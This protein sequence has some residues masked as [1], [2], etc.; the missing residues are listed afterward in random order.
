MLLTTI[1]VLAVSLSALVT[2]PTVDQIY[3]VKRIYDAPLSGENEVPPVQSSATGLAEFTPP[4]NDTIK[5]RINIT[6][7]SGATGAH[8][9][10]GQ[11]GENG[12]VVV[13]LLTSMKAN[14]VS[15]GMTIRGNISDS[16][17]KGPMEGKTLEDLV[18][19]MDSGQ[20]YVNI[21][22]TEHP[23]GE[24]RG[25]II[26]TEKAGSTEQAEANNSTTPT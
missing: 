16:S 21:H 25:Q 26:N 11:A 20:T 6:G 14:D 17:L 10:S 5:Y 12:E 23:D 8:I 7:I 18:A 1:L 13:D 9:H 2:L 22:T 15:Y 4:V 3:A 19:A 24:I